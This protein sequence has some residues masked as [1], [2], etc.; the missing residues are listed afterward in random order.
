MATI[1]FG[2]GLL[3]FWIEPLAVLSAMEQ[4][5]PNVIYRVR[6]QRPV[7]ALSFDD[8]PHPTFT[9]QFLEIL[10]RHDAKA[11][12]FL[13]GERAVRHPEVVSQIK[14]AGHE[15]GNHYFR[16]GPTLWHSDAEFVDYL[17]QTEKAISIISGPKLFRP[18]GGVAWSRAAQNAAEKGMERRSWVAV[19]EYSSSG[20]CTGTRS[21]NRGGTRGSL[22]IKA[23]TWARP[24]GTGKKPK[25]ATTPTRWC[26]PA[27]A[28][29]GK[30]G[31]CDAATK[32]ARR[33]ILLRRRNIC[34]RLNARRRAT[35]R[36]ARRGVAWR[37]SEIR[38]A[39]PQLEFSKAGLR[40]CQAN[41]VIQA[42]RRR[43]MKASS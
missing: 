1:L 8:G 21:G 17:E 32:S 39:M 23:S 41:D 9:L 42:S 24:Y 36:S 19:S 43:V 33:S 16:N 29:R 18:P 34:G 3:V 22:W 20:R 40:A 38:N 4:F 30:R 27:A 12:F 7:V 14:A 13:I 26:S 5:T 28:L 6:T 2:A 15:V 37:C 10:R 25:P 35:A 11:T 31:S